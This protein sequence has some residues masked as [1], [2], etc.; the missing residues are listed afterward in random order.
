MT[1]TQI[2]ITLSEK[3]HEFLCAYSKAFDMPK[4]YLLMRALRAHLGISGSEL[5]DKEEFE[6]LMEDI[7]VGHRWRTVK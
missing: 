6:S 3:E 2:R 5:Y 1:T 4:S 7:T